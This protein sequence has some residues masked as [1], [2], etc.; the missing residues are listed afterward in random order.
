[1]SAEA[2]EDALE[3]EQMARHDAAEALVQNDPN[4]RKY[5]DRWLDA[6][7]Y[8]EDHPNRIDYEMEEMLFEQGWDQYQSERQ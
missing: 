1:M 3:Q 2:Y 4:V 8:L 6:Y 7:D 5:I